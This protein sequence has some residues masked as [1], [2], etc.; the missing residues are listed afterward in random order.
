MKKILV[1]IVFV[2]FMP[3]CVYAD[4]NG[5]KFND[6][7]DW[8]AYWAIGVADHHYPG[9]LDSVLNALESLPG[10]D[11]TQLEFDMLGF[12]WPIKNR[13]LLG[14]VISGSA[15]RCADGYG[16]YMQLNHYLYGLSSMHFFGKSIGDGFYVRGDIGIAKI[17]ID[18]S[19]GSAN[20]NNGSGILLGV[21][22]GWPISHETRILVGLSTSSY[23]VESESYSTTSITVGGLW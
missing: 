6:T 17:N 15:D 3:T 22:Y 14:F 16:N 23:S 12:Y 8:Y 5:G 4:G 10:V 7:E 19:F 21:G 1:S 18:S 2:L 13:T 11:R 20:S 9:S